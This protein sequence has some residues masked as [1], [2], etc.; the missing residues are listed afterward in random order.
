MDQSLKE[1]IIRS[2][3]FDEAISKILARVKTPPLPQCRM[4][5][6]M[7]GISIEHADSIRMLA[8]SNN[9]TSAIS[10]LRIQ[11]ETTA[12]A[13]WLLFAADKEYIE[14]HDSPLTVE[15][16]GYKDGP[17]IEKILKDLDAH[18]KVPR[19]AVIRLRE[20]KSESWK[21]LGSFVHGGKHPLKRKQDGYPLHLVLTLTK[22]SNAL[23]IMV[24]M[25]VIM[26]SGDEKLSHEFWL[27]QNVF[28]DCLPP[29][30]L[31]NS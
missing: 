18:P 30:I 20:F 11:Y 7:A 16:D 14:L 5:K 13:I 22:H 17:N 29:Y 26:M 28:K 21:A 4:S 25:T 8:Y 1:L 3:E 23:L 9:L 15:S 27:L 10:L 31:Q 24:V 2:A 12:R 19:D 6:A